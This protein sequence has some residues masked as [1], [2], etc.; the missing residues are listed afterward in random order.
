M[1]SK[2]PRV[3]R[4]ILDKGH[5]R[6]NDAYTEFLDARRPTRGRGVGTY[7]DYGVC[8]RSTLEGQLMEVGGV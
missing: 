2:L 5:A 3:V 6:S 4:K 8:I 7:P 1:V